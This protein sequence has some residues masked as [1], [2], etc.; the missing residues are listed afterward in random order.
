MQRE[1]TDSQLMDTWRLVANSLAEFLPILTFLILSETKGF[2]TG[3]KGLIIV[4]VICIIFSWYIEKRI[5][6]FGLFASGTIVL[7]GSLSLFFES[8]FFIILKDTLYN[9]FFALILLAGLLRGTSLLKTF[10]GDFFAMTDRGWM[11]L[12]RRWMFFFFLLTI[13]NEIARATLTP[14]VWVIYKFGALIITWIF[15]FYQFT[16]A[17]RERLPEASSW[18]LRLKH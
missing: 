17:R 6:K 15:G 3:I 12:S 11:I 7:F 2:M 9:L 10:F 4:A 5:P 1:H 13:G 18:G 8:S 16:L 14:E